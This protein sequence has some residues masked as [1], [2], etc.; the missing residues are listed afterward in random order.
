MAPGAETEAVAAARNA[1]AA[2][3][4]DPNAYV[5]FGNALM[6]ADRYDEAIAQFRTALVLRP[7]HGPTYYNIGNAQL[8]ARRPADAEV[9]Y[10][11]A[12][13]LWPGHAG[14]LNN[15][16]NA[17]R[18]QGRLD[19]AAASYRSALRVDANLPG[20]LNNLGG[21]LIALNRHDMAIEP[22]ASAVRLDPAYAEA[23]NNLGGALLTCGRPAEA[24]LWFE[25]AVA[26]DPDNHQA[27]FGSALALLAQGR[28]GEGWAAYEWR[29]RD[30]SFVA[31]TPDFIPPRWTGAQDV[32]G[33]TMLLWAEQGLGDTIQF[34]RYAPLVARL[35][36]NVVL[37]VD[38]ALVGVLAP[39]ATK[40]IATGD[41]LPDFELHC[42]L[43]SL[44]LAFGT[45]ASGI[46]ADIPYLAT[47][48]ALRAKWRAALGPPTRPRIGIA[49]SGNSD[50]SDDALRSISVAALA[51]LLART[52]V[53]IH[54]V[55]RDVRDSD[56]AA[57]AAWPSV[58]RHDRDL[59]D[60]A[61]T[62]ALLA[63]LDLIVSVDTS[64]A[65]LAGA[66]GLQ[67]WTLLPLGADFRWLRDRHDSPW[68]PT[69]RLFRQERFG[70]WGDVVERLGQALGEWVRQQSAGSLNTS[71][72]S[73]DFA[74]SRQD[75]FIL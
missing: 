4:H 63:E 7:H 42:P 47:E 73:D 29:W 69:M 52:G 46:P 10:R 75:G 56:G 58:S 36:A 39:L 71:A 32:A 51:P 49:F 1:L 35:G 27:R 66:L 64:V 74:G 19:E 16:G 28:F 44:P 48:A 17:L 55:Q 13:A 38:R 33:R 2:R 53:S 9:S 23:C 21:V 43:M 31:D 30:P 41:A 70:D 68:Y 37:R 60:F 40:V 24:A 25:R 26:L 12:L 34:A 59:T 15:L 61:E 6:Q 67:V 22:L 18:A 62:A 14:T 20:T 72:Q 45:E 8:G 54:V 5:D 3:A 65:H 11:L 50:L 57:L